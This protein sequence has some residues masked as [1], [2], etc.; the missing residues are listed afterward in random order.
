MTLADDLD[1]HSRRIL[2]TGAANGFG[3]AMAGLF[4]AAGADLVLADIEDQPLAEV[5]QRCG[6]AEVHVY[7]QADPASVGSL[8]EAAGAVDILI[9]NAG[10]LVA[11]P[12]L[13]TGLE[14][15]RRV[16]DVDLIGAV[17]LMQLVGAGMVR[18]RQGVI[19]SIGSQTAFSGGENRAIYAAA[20]AA[21]SQ[22]TKAA[23]VEWGPHGVRVLCLAP[24]RSLTR[25]SRQTVKEGQSGDRGLARVPLGRWGTAEEIAKLAMFLV[26]DAASY[27]TGETVI[28]D[29]GYVIG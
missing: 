5:A 12:L 29:G 21:I 14:E 28:A 8:A 19:L 26:S 25:L 6:N 7:D 10:V 27:V 24:G 3:A 13:D 22:V 23:A 9:N 15:M 17:R 18:R 16:I 2:I 1:F 4:H 11:K 20:K